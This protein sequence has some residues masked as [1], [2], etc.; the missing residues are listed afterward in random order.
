MLNY[1]IGSRSP[2]TVERYVNL[3]R[4]VKEL[5]GHSHSKVTLL[6]VSRKIVRG[7][8][9]PTEKTSKTGRRGGFCRLE[10]F[11]CVCKESSSIQIKKIWR[12]SSKSINLILT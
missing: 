1:V 11:G 4:V 10:L 5:E 9:D 6:S 3:L 2:E 7:K 8:T 12:K